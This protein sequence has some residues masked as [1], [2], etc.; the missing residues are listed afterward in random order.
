LL[1]TII[2]TRLVAS[3][4]GTFVHQDA[5]WN[6]SE[7]PAPELDRGIIDHSGRGKIFYLVATLDYLARGG[8]IGYASA[9]LGNA[10]Q[11]IPISTLTDE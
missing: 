2:N 4:Q 3:L 5:L 7:V 11:V 6:R 9:L 10:M 8:R 1:F